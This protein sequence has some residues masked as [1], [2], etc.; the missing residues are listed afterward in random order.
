M[1][2]DGGDET[3][4]FGKR[5]WTIRVATAS[6]GLLSFV[7]TQVL[8]SFYNLDIALLHVEFFRFYDVYFLRL[9]HRFSRLSDRNIPVA[10][11]TKKPWQTPHIFT[12]QMFVRHERAGNADLMFITHP[13]RFLCLM[14][15][16]ISHFFLRPLAYNYLENCF[17]FFLFFDNFQFYILWNVFGTQTTI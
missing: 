10:K 13:I 15:S 17:W 16:R 14:F 1:I 9:Y 4:W 3:S 6:S 12:F 11:F 5:V 7:Y 2:S 8:F